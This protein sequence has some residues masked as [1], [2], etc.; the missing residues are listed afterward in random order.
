M[1]A[2]QSGFT[3]IE[4]MIAVAALAILAAVALPS[5][6][7]Y[8]RRGQQ[9]EAFNA[10][11]D[12]RAKMEQYYQDNRNYGNATTCANDSTASGWNAFPSS[13]YFNFACTITDATTFQA[14]SISATGRSGQV[15]GDVYSIDQNGNRTTSN[16]RGAE[17]TANC[18]LTKSDTC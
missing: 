9:A 12:Y 7:S 14:Y 5:Y 13:Q 4:L 16:F 6:N 10:L 3:L 2:E 11:S 15:N 17:V 18:W 1:R 8:I